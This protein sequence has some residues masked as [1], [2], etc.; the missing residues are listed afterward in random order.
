MLKGLGLGL[1][2]GLDIPCTIIVTHILD[3]YNCTHMYVTCHVP[4]GRY[5]KHVCMYSMQHVQYLFIYVPMYD[6]RDT[7]S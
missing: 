5:V 7:H 4:S 3:R 6:H 1:G 2:L